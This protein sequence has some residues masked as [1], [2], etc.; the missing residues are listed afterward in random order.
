M[1]KKI[2][3]ILLAV[4]LLA[5]SVQI[6]ASANVHE[7]RLWRSPDSTRVV[8]DMS[9]AAKH[10]VFTLSSPYRVVLDIQNATM[11]ANL[12]SLELVNTPVSNIRFAKQGSSG[13][14]VVLDMSR[15]VGVRSFFLKKSGEAKDR[16]VLDLSDVTSAKKANKSQK[17]VHEIK[18]G[19]R[20]IIIA[21]DAG[22]GG[23]DPGAIGPKKIYE[24]TVVLEI[25]KALKAQFD[26]KKGYKAILVR[27]G[28]Y[29]IPLAKRRDIA[30]KA[31][32]DMF[33]SVHA[34]AFSSPKAYGTSVYALSSKG[35][36][37]TFARFLA[38]KE[39]KSDLVGGVSLSD[40]D[41]VLSSVLLDLSMTHKM[42]SSLEIGDHVLGHMGE[43]SRLH[44]RRVE[45]AAFAVLKT[46]DIPS[47]LI[48]T[49][50]ISNPGEAKKLAT[51]S[52][53]K[54]MAN[55][56]YQGVNDWFSEN[57][58]EDTYIAQQFKKGSNSSIHI[59]SSGDTL[60]GVAS[61]YG[62]SMDTVKKTNKLRSNS[63][64]IG[65]RLTIPAK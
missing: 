21:I 52:Y 60:S 31:D 48:E 30:R 1:V 59:V 64:K 13:V 38:D 4:Y 41:A 47:L 57:A 7:V 55:A 27:T 28:D 14:R 50:F 18:K 3:S 15:A 34:D 10:K 8:F 62:V 22:H 43:I 25:A 39:N 17:T 24:K 49:G 6:F 61:R 51:K 11:S 53:R 9:A 19:R 45:Q 63:L 23:E 65:Q 42:Q 29:Y 5:V 20:D 44:S 16:L 40:K 32:A 12:S 56:I 35:A 54:K 33:I 58:S 2:S 26:A 36:T 37:S 46:P